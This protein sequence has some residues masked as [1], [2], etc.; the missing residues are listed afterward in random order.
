MRRRSQLEEDI[1][2]IGHV[3]GRRKCREAGDNKAGRHVPP[4]TL[5]VSKKTERPYKAIKMWTPVN[6]AQRWL[7]FA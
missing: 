4:E 6:D 5:W 7:E 1:R 3:K 2:V